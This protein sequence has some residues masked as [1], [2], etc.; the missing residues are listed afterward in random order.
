[1]CSLLPSESTHGGPSPLPEATDSP[2]A[3]RVNPA[4]P[5]SPTHRVSLANPAH[6]ASPASP[7]HRASLANPAHRASPPKATTGHSEAAHPTARWGGLVLRG[8]AAV[9]AFCADRAM[10][11]GPS[12]AVL[13]RL[14]Q[15]PRAKQVRPI[16]PTQPPHKGER[17]FAGAAAR[18]REHRSRRAL[19]S[20]ESDALNRERHI[21]PV[22]PTKRASLTNES[23]ALVCE[24]RSL[25]C[26]G[27]NGA[28]NRE[29]CSRSRPAL[30][31]SGALGR[32]RCSRVK[33]SARWAW[34][35]RW[36]GSSRRA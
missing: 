9:V 10:L 8:V 16:E 30:R 28:L 5:A 35:R 31:E 24:R 19:L 33:A 27:V 18:I 25:A 14:A 15:G 26:G 4:N 7:T 21:A 29:H 20:K 13:P 32:E 12:F 11:F 6:R 17:R 34:R 2:S 22:S 36:S 1:M 3:P 23:T